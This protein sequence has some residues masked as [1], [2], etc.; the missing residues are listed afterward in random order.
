MY[1]YIC[2]V[3]FM[4]IYSYTALASIREKPFTLAL[5]L[6][7]SLSINDYST[8]GIGQTQM[9]NFGYGLG[10][11]ISIGYQVDHKLA[12]NVLF[13]YNT[14]KQ[15]IYQTELHNIFDEGSYFSRV[16][17]FENYTIGL[18]LAYR[19]K[20]FNTKNF[21]IISGL[22]YSFLNQYGNKVAYHLNV[23]P[24]SD[25]IDFSYGS[26]QEM[27][28]WSLKVRHFNIN[29]G[30]EI[31]IH[32]KNSERLS[33][34]LLYVLPTSIMPEYD[35]YSKIIHEHTLYN[36]QTATKSKQSLLELHIKY[37]LFKF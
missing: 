34:G 22:S 15:E 3:L 26:T 30:F 25:I 7:P 8:T 37:N 36:T 21:K 20:I 4:L 11:H 31:P 32:I 19:L 10:G 9:K 29:L 27:E 17:E 12:L 6:N 33:V 5:G 1:R 16:W 23:K 35:F 13:K 24:N 2:I 18:L 14:Q 28:D